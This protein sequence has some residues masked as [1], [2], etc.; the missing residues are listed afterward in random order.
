MSATPWHTA[1]GF[2][3]DAVQQLPPYIGQYKHSHVGHGTI[4]TIYHLQKGMGK[5]GQLYFGGKMQGGEG[6]KLKTE[7]SVQDVIYHARQYI[8]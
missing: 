7:I 5:A 4:D 8:L 3:R 6:K 2:W 1:L